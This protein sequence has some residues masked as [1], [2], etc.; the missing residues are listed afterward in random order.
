MSAIPNK[1]TEKTEK[2]RL[3]ESLKEQIKKA[4]SKGLYDTAHHAMLKQ[5]E[6]KE[7]S[8]G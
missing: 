8:N 1:K 3:I 6:G 5:I 2:E 7:Q 4:E